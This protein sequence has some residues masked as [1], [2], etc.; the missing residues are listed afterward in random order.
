MDEGTAPEPCGCEHADHFPAD[1]HFPTPQTKHGYLKATADG[2]HFNAW[3][4][5]L[6]AECANVCIT[7]GTTQET[8][9]VTLDSL[10]P[11]AG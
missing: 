7:A 3:V 4:G 10:T 1:R 11:N 6:C 5:A 8:V 2:V 9:A